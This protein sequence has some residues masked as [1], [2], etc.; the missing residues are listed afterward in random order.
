MDN[1]FNYKCYTLEIKN[2]L[3]DHKESF[4]T[5]VD[6][7]I[8]EIYDTNIKLGNFLSFFKA[9]KDNMIPCTAYSIK[10]HLEYSN[11]MDK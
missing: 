10:R 2:H 5:Q 7:E 9:D 1:K 6:E 3:I 11:D 4:L 8:K